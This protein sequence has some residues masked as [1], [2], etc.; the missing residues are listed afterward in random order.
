MRRDIPAATKAQDN[1]ALLEEREL[2]AAVGW[3]VDQILELL[4]AAEPKI[5]ARPPWGLDASADPPVYRHWLQKQPANNGAVPQLP[6]DGPLISIVVPVYRPELWYFRACVESV[7]EQRYRSWELCL[8]DDGSAD[9]DLT[10]MIEELQKS[11]PRLKVIRHPQNKGISSAT[12]SALALASGEYVALVDH[13]DL[14][15]HDALSEVALAVR[16]APDADVVYTDE[17]KVDEKNQRFC[18]YFKPDWAPELL[19]AYPYLGHLVVVRRS[20]LD[21]IGGFSPHFDGSQDF[22]VMLRAT[23]KSRSIVH[24]AKV[25]YHWR[26]VAGS[27]ARDSA[28]KPWAHQASRR[29]VEETVRRRNIA[30][31]VE[32]GPFPGSY[33][34]LRQ[35]DGNPSVR[36]IVPFRDQ[37]A[38]TSRCVTSLAVAPGYDNY[39]V[40]LVDNG[41]TE[42]E[43][44][45]FRD[46][47]RRSGMEILEYPGSFNWSAINNLAASDCDSDLLLFLNNDIEALKEGWL[48]ALVELAQLPEVGAVGARL[49]F[50]DGVLQHGGIVVGMGG[51]AGHLFCGMPPGT[52][53][54]F[55]WDRVT[56]PYG[57]VTGACMMSRREVFSAVGGFDE[58]LE[59]AFNDVDYCMRLY[60]A[61]Y[62]VLYT[63]HAEMMH[64][65]SLSR[66]ISGY[67][68]DVR[69]FL[70]KWSR[71]RLRDDP[72]YNRNLS[73]FAPWCALREPDETA[74]WESFLDGLQGL[75]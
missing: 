9:R 32:D 54:Y 30:A 72:Y 45:A 56:R 25:L 41:S 66:G 12:N 3:S 2:T 1:G 51:I 68:H 40:V 43:T 71:E 15:H 48:R 6:T 62:R 36:I 13:D 31:T 16:G 44:I 20:L 11:E 47:A 8:C 60:D 55:G 59:V 33:N 38:L 37:A 34:V 39:E 64:D 21:A 52:G 75:S 61:G 69:Y 58:A 28:A 65:E 14:L 67:V 74:R 10:T 17:D 23:E 73:L 49:L 70:K 22:D 24:I 53:G 42:P 19:L 50:P 5:E 46:R 26:A 4:P 27:A 7:F 63:P 57:A 35:V 18:P 29:V